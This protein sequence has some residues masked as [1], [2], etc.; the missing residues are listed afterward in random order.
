MRLQRVNEIL[1][2]LVGDYELR[3]AT[4]LISKTNGHGGKLPKLE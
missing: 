2:K 4:H 1:E 3:A